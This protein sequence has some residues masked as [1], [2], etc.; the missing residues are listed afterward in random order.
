MPVFINWIGPAGRETID[1]FETRK[2]ARAMLV[3]YQIAGM[4]GA[5]LSSRMCANW[6][7][8]AAPAPSRAKRRTYTPRGTGYRAFD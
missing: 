2:E 8:A 6:R 4:A 1:E 3:E 7:D 5:H